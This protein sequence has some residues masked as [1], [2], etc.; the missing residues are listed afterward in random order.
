MSR[1]KFGQ[2]HHFFATILARRRQNGPRLRQTLKAGE[3]RSPDPGV[4]TGSTGFYRQVKE[5]L[6]AIMV[7]MN[8]AEVLSKLDLASITI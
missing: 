1:K 8:E 7:R 3:P 2:K 4:S 5:G 6:K